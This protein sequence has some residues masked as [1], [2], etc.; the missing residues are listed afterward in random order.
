[1]QNKW[2]LLYK[3]SKYNLLS[4][5]SGT[6]I[7]FICPWPDK[8]VTQ[9]SGATINL[10]SPLQFYVN[11]WCDFLICKKM[12]QCP[13]MTCSIMS[14]Y[15]GKCHVTTP[16]MQ[17]WP[18]AK[19]PRHKTTIMSTTEGNKNIYPDSGAEVR[20]THHQPSWTANGSVVHCQQTPPALRSKTRSAPRQ[21]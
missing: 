4:R 9:H 8:Q 18:A 3:Q 19:V 15:C 2:D 6:L 14:C 16:P 12:T 13:V 7:L 1:M 11:Q 20:N 5:T 10:Y 21:R 17:K